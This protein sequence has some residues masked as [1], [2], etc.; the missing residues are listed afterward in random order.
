M[1]IN[2]IQRQP[3]SVDDVTTDRKS[4]DQRYDSCVA[5]TAPESAPKGTK[6]RTASVRI[7]QTKTSMIENCI[8]SSWNLATNCSLVISGASYPIQYCF[9]RS[10]NRATAPPRGMRWKNVCKAAMRRLRYIATFRRSILEIGDLNLRKSRRNNCSRAC[11]SQSRT[12]EVGC[13][14][15]DGALLSG[16]LSKSPT[17]VLLCLHGSSS[18]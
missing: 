8:R 6:P 3:W 13:L 5:C 14:G 12:L 9:Q 18:V 15:V 1:R 10:T 11:R 7:R 4:K 16:S 17:S 2:R